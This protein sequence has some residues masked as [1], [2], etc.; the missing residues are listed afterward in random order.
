MDLFFISL[1]ILMLLLII[2]GTVAWSVMVYRKA[3]RSVTRSEAL[4]EAQEWLSRKVGELEDEL[5]AFKREIAENAPQS[6]TEG[7][8]QRERIEREYDK[9]FAYQPDTIGI[10]YTG[11]PQEDDE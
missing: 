6:A 5:V 10:K 7:D 3:V 1:I 11:E 4:A 2:G 9:L 8:K